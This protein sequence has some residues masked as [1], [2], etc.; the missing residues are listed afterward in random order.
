M[1]RCYLAYRGRISGNEFK[2]QIVATIDRFEQEITNLTLEQLEIRPVSAKWSAQEIAFHALRAAI[3]MFK[4]C[5]LLRKGDDLPDLDRSTVGRTRAVTK[6]E[7][8]KVCLEA[9]EQAGKFHYE[10]HSKATC[11][12]PLLG[13]LDFY[14]WL[15][16]N[17][18]HLERHYRQLQR[19]VSGLN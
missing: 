1:V 19:T 13:K 16:M 14:G 10:S 8:L 2:N 5:D 18:V 12:H 17:M 9:K 6:E 7:L 15:S 4:L 3:S 11:R